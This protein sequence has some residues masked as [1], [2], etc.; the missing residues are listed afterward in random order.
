MAYNIIVADSSPTTQ[1]II[2]MELTAPDFV[3]SSCPSREELLKKLTE[4]KPHAIILNLSLP[5]SD[6]YELAAYLHSRPDLEKVPLILLQNAFELVDE[7]RLA[8]LVFVDLIRK[9]FDSERISS[10]VKKAVG[11]PE[12]PDSLPE[13][14][15]FETA[16]LDEPEDF[17]GEKAKELMAMIQPIITKEIISLERELEKRLQARLRSELQAWLEEKWRG[18]LKEREQNE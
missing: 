14:L 2:E 1:K 10:A 11:L 17:Y 5:D 18:L 3:V 16:L 9:P 8:S 15:E 4:V 12:E 6:G 7:K 13:E